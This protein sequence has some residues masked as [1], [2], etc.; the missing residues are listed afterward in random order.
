MSLFFY[1][2]KE[3]IS[4]KEAINNYNHLS[5]ECIKQTPSL[6]EA[7]NQMYVSTGL[8]SQK[9]YELTNDIVLK[10][11]KIIEFNFDL[12]NVKYPLLTRDE[13]KILSSYICEAKDPYY[14]PYKILNMNL[15]EENRNKSIKRISKYFYIYI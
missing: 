15:C 3:D 14:N 10:S 13:T 12:I 6:S 11:E 9:A 8:S 1:T 4:K 2:G 5:K 7:L